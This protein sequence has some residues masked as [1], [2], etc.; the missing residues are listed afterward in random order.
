MVEKAKQNFV[1]KKEPSS[2][3]VLLLDDEP[4]NIEALK[5]ILECLKLRGLP[6]SIDYTY[7]AEKALMML[8]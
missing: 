5:S 6:E 2:K 7:Y 3:K 1:N 4:Y 8:D